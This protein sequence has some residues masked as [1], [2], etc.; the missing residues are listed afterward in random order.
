ER[1]VLVVSRPMAARGRF[2]ARDWLERGHSCLAAL[3]SRIADSCRSARSVAPAFQL[4]RVARD[5]YHHGLLSIHK[6]ICTAQKRLL[7]KRI[8]LIRTK[9]SHQNLGGGQAIEM[10]FFNFRPMSLGNVL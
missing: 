1:P 8:E 3:G 6:H 9:R 10:P 7:P 4:L 5:T 2:A